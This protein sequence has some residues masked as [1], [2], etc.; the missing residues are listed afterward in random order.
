MATSPEEHDEQGIEKIYADAFAS[1]E[2]DVVAE[3]LWCKA[4]WLSFHDEDA[5]LRFRFSWGMEGYEDVSA[6]PLKQTWAGK[7][8]DVLFPESAI[9]TQNN[10]ILDH[11]SSI[12]EQKTIICRKDCLF[13]RT[14]WRRTVSS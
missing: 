8:C 1:N 11:L 10:T 12:L 2:D 13:Q 9:I 3:E 5:S 4:S 7:L 6:D 14:Q